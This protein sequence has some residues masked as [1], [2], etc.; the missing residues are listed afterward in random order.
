MSGACLSSTRYTKTTHNET[1]T[2]IHEQQRSGRERSDLGEA[3]L[4]G[5]GR[6]T[7][8]ARRV[9]PGIVGRRS[10]QRVSSSTISPPMRSLTCI[11]KTFSR[12]VRR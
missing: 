8:N 4:T 5:E 2:S 10:R 6:Q 11:G 9:P 3:G 12:L 1:E 7:E